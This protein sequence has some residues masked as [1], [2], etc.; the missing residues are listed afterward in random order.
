MGRDGEVWRV[1]RGREPL[2]AITIDGGDFP[3]LS[4]GGRAGWLRGAEGPPGRAW[5]DATKLDT[6]PIGGGREPLS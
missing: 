2:G 4:A 1:V 5:A 3:W 6:V